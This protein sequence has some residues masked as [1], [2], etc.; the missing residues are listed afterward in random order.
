[1]S[2]VT[3]SIGGKEYT[4]ACADGEEAHVSALGDQI[5]A[6]V[7]RI[8]E[9][10]TPQETQKM[11]FGALFLADELHEATK[12]VEAAQ[13]ASAEAQKQTDAAT[14]AQGELN[15]K[16]AT[17]QAE[18]D[19]LKLAQKSHVS[20][21]EEVRTELT[22]RREESEECRSELEKTTAHVAELERERSD[23]SAKLE[24]ASNTPAVGGL[25]ASL[26]DDPDLAPA[27]E[28]FADLLETCANKL[29]A[30]TASS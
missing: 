9:G 25:H 30:G 27:L 26:A 21:L 14:T 5:D 10:T 1:M 12:A 16:I 13:T 29:E 11:L 20:E 4:V 3:L 23:L 24:E 8:A 15:Q 19:G 2:E 18:L 28:R 7:S 17:L 22:Q 6:R